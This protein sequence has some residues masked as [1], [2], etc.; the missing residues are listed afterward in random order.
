MKSPKKIK[1][2]VYNALETAL[3]KF[4]LLQAT[5]SKW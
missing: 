1:V 5:D 4:Y 2:S 3:L